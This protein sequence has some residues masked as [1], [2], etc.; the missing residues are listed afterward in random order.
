MVEPVLKR[1]CDKTDPSHYQP[2]SI[3]SAVAKVFEKCINQHIAEY[4]E[5]NKII[6]DRQYG[7]RE[8]RSTTDLLTNNNMAKPLQSHWIYP[9]HLTRYG[10]RILSVKLWHMVLIRSLCLCLT[11]M[12]CWIEP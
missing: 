5:I 9:K 11:S 6:S 8:S 12:I 3:V 10:T 7:F 2:I 1:G 4:L